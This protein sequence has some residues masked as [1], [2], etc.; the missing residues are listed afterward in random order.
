MLVLFW[1]DV[2]RFENRNKKLSLVIY[3]NTNFCACVRAFLCYIRKGVVVY[4]D[5]EYVRILESG[6]FLLQS[7][8]DMWHYIENT[9]R[10]SKHNKVINRIL[11]SSNFLIYFQKFRVEVF[12]L[13]LKF[14]LK[15]ILFQVDILGDFEN[16]TAWPFFTLFFF[17]RPFSQDQA[18]NIVIE[19]HEKALH[20]TYS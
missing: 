17:G 13:Y 12:I 8:L 14:W 20:Y 9:F 2:H 7:L 6:A 11:L 3:F 19:S 16:L 18:I 10:F 15:D 5:F 4:S 1:L